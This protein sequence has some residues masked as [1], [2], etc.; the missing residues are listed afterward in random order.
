VVS[1][2]VASFINFDAA[3][4]ATAKATADRS[5]S[6]GSSP[7]CASEKQPPF[8]SLIEEAIGGSPG[9][10]PQDAGETDEDIELPEVDG[11]E[12]NV[13]AMYAWNPPLRHAEPAVPLTL[14]IAW[15][16]GSAGAKPELDPSDGF[17]QDTTLPGARWQPADDPGQTPSGVVVALAGNRMTANAAQVAAGTLAAA[18]AA[19]ADPSPV[20]WEPSSQ[21]IPTQLAAVVRIATGRER[22]SD[23][24]S[25]VMHGNQI[26]LG[27]SP[28]PPPEKTLNKEGQIDDVSPVTAMRSGPGEATAY[29]SAASVKQA[30]SPD[31]SPV[32]SPAQQSGPPDND[33]ERS[34]RAGKGEQAA[35][36]LENT[37]AENRRAHPQDA[38]SPERPS[39]KSDL[40]AQPGMTGHGFSGAPDK[41][42]RKETPQH[43][44]KS[45]AA[46]VTA[47]EVQD[48]A[49]G[50]AERIAIRLDG[51]P[52]GAVEIH[53]QERRGEVR[54]SLRAA[55]PEMV[56][57]IR[58]SLPE[59]SERLQG[60]GLK[61]ETWRPDETPRA[62]PASSDAASQDL[63]RDGRGRQYRQDAEPQQFSNGGQ[64]RD[65]NFAG[66]F[67]TEQGER[68]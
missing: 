32:S 16:A 60:E 35:A 34:Q 33:Q 14:N 59:L 6:S 52:G 42:E 15:A 40:G 9:H 63:Y 22:R 67:E 1:S 24:A 62:N 13:A 29:T 23:P 21:R 56:A 19:P 18:Q 43:P 8:R 55:A 47:H 37:A 48:R 66:V 50:K 17:W 36:S 54:L 4:A 31:L 51:T 27:E 49:T 28:N 5:G 45:P 26:P 39:E 30:A 61:A 46:N 10:Q 7:G 68:E 11:G 44:A 38:I 3:A 41:P 12:A 2:A 64:P 57:R 53:L 58:E 65:E 25:H 20:G